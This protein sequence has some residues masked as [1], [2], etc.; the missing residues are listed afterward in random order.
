MN[1]ILVATRA[2]GH[3][4]KTG[5][6]GAEVFNENDEIKHTKIWQ[7]ISLRASAQDKHKDMHSH[8][9]HLTVIDAF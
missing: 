1:Y 8:A 5:S 6:A 9:L 4:Q 2:F 7:Q 3:E